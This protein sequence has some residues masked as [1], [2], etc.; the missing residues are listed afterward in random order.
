MSIAIFRQNNNDIAV[1]D[2]TEWK[3]FQ[4]LPRFTNNICQPREFSKLCEF[5]AES[6]I[7]GGE[8]TNF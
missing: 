7:S 1:K 3:I 2:R 6:T 4:S 8:V 5:Y